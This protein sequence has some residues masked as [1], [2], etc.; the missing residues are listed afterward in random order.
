MLH[1][2]VFF[3]SI[4]TVCLLKYDVSTELLI[5]YGKLNTLKTALQFSGSADKF[6]VNK[7]QKSHREGH[8]SEPATCNRCQE[9]IVSRSLDT[10]PG[11][12]GSKQHVLWP[13]EVT[14]SRWIRP[15]GKGW[16]TAGVGWTRASPQATVPP[17]DRLAAIAGHLASRLTTIIIT[18]LD[19]GH[20]NYSLARGYLQ[21]NNITFLC[22]SFYVKLTLCKLWICSKNVTTKI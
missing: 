9:A 16:V 8:N 4:A 20:A 12:G 17:Q 1:F 13:E 6:K 7:G 19:P 22:I 11:L 15:R 2:N 3:S 14:R 5:S 21:L 18:N 10:C